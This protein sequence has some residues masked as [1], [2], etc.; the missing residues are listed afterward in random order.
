[1]EKKD[2]LAIIPARGGSKG[3]P[4]KN[5]ADLCGK[6]LIAYTIEVALRSRQIT[7]VIVS[8]DDDEIAA[9]SESYG[10]EIPFMRPRELAHDEA[11]VSDA[12]TYTLDTLSASGYHPDAF[13]SLYPTHVFRTP[14]LVDSLIDV[15]F[16]GYQNVKTV[17]RSDLSAGKTVSMGP[18]HALWPLAFEK[19]RTYFRSYGIFMGQMLTGH[20]PYGT[21]LHYLEDPIS[22]VDIDERRDLELA[23]K[24]IGQ[25]LFDFGIS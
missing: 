14:R 23:R 2:V 22:F 7:R 3:I 20:Q 24:I 5:I 15:M 6:P 9:I 12:F 11:V 13:I 18:D 19:D 10:A 4:K 17:K 25:S 21:Y 16:R 8:T 1:M